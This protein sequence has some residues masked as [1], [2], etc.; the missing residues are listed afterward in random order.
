MSLPWP[1]DGLRDD[2]VT[3]FRPMRATGEGK[4]PFVLDPDWPGAILLPTG[5]EKD[6]TTENIGSQW[7]RAPGLAR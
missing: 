5:A 6:A 1:R 2:H 7:R 4:A 3:P